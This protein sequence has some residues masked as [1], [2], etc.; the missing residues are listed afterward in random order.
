MNNRRAGAKR[1]EEGIANPGAQDN[2]APPQ[3]NRVPPL[4]EVAMGNR[5]SVVP[6]PMTDEDI[7]EDFLNFAQPV[8]SQANIVTFLVQVMTTQV[9]REVGLRVP[10]H[11][12]TMASRLRDFT[13]MNPPLFYGSKEDEDLQDF[14]D[15][16]YMILFSI[17]VTTGEKAELDAYQLKDVAQTW[18]TQWRD[19]RVLG[20]DP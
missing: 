14:L 18:Y 15:E 1:A 12:N 3:D 7:R 16:V 5:N 8:T 20:G 4:E 9:N 6:P 17:G 11:A 10:Q 13:R 19:N 2:Q